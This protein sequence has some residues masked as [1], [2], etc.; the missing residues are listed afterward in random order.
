MLEQNQESNQRENN[1]SNK[2]QINEEQ[3]AQPNVAQP[4]VAQPK[5][6]QV[7]GR[8]LNASNKGN[9]S[10]PFEGADDLLP[11]EDERP[12]DS[13]SSPKKKLILI[14]VIVLGV[15]L[16]SG[17]LLFAADRI[18]DLEIPFISKIFREE[19]SEKIIGEIIVAESPEDVIK[20]MFVSFKNIKTSQEDLNLKITE[21]D[22]VTNIE[23]NG[24]R[25]FTDAE[26]RKLDYTFLFSEFSSNTKVSLA[27]KYLD[28]TAYINLVEVPWTPLIDLSLFKNQ[29]FYLNEQDRGELNQLYGA[30]EVEPQGEY[31]QSILE[32]FKQAKLFNVVKVFDE[33][34]IDSAMVVH[35]SV[36]LD[37]EGVL[38]FF[39]EL[40]KVGQDK[41]GE[42]QGLPISFPQERFDYAKETLDGM[43]DMPIEVWIEKENYFLRKVSIDYSGV[44][45]KRNDQ[46]SKANILLTLELNNINQP[47]GIGIEA[48]LGAQSLG[49][50]IEGVLGGL[51]QEQAEQVLEQ[52]VETGE[53][54]ILDGD[55]DNDNLTDQE[56]VFYNTDPLNPDT[57]GDGYLDGDEVM[58]GYNPAGEGKLFTDTEFFPI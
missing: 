10:Q 38:E 19:D 47:I 45:I 56:E 42:T 5:E 27:F 49:E 15:I 4:N 23:L 35:Y 1:R 33:E 30:D 3:I 6:E 58:S 26:N 12:L 39:N 51:T 44:D 32:I 8:E 52:D 36:A 16:V 54:N 55:Q 25:D 41:L 37:S 46:I 57:D 53:L 20:K 40:E 9:L 13:S 28:E 50:V 14:V 18:F 11:K 43:K 31:D 21:G 2:R 48:P 24:K 34:E 22:K 29:W 17:G 7:G